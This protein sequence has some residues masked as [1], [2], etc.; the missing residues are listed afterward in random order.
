MGRLCIP[1]L[2]GELGHGRAILPVTVDMKH[3]QYIHGELRET[4]RSEL[5]SRMDIPKCMIAVECISSTYIWNHAER[6]NFAWMLIPCSGSQGYCKQHF[7]CKRCEK[8]SLVKHICLSMYD[9]D[10]FPGNCGVVDNYN[11]SAKCKAEWALYIDWCHKLKISVPKKDRWP[12]YAE[13]DIEYPCCKRA[14]HERFLES[15]L[16]WGDSNFKRIEAVL[17]QRSWNV[18]VEVQLSDAIFRELGPSLSSEQYVQHP[19]R[20]RQFNIGE[21]FYDLY[22]LHYLALQSR[23]MGDMICFLLDR[24][25]KYIG[26]CADVNLSINGMTAIDYAVY[27]NC[28]AEPC[29]RNNVEHLIACGAVATLRTLNMSILK[30][31]DRVF[32]QVLN[33]FPAL[34]HACSEGDLPRY[35]SFKQ[36][37]AI[38][39][40]A[41]LGKVNFVTRLIKYGADVQSEYKG[42]TLDEL[43]LN[44]GHSDAARQIRL[45]LKR[46]PS[47]VTEKQIK[48][49]GFIAVRPLRSSENRAQDIDKIFHEE[50]GEAKKLLREIEEL[51]LKAADCEISGRNASAKAYKEA[52][53]AIKTEMPRVQDEAGD[54]IFSRVNDGRLMIQVDLHGLY[55]NEAVKKTD[56]FLDHARNIAK[57]CPVSVKFIT[58]RGARSTDTAQLRPRVLKH[59]QD[60]RLVIDEE[61]GALTITMRHICF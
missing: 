39:W 54:R 3:E 58:G 32:D 14:L 41:H 4:V 48:H 33:R 35:P 61:V 18:C 19:N 49:E 26:R 43:A 13:S 15:L 38:C 10:R 45:L 27:A 52:I 7:Y 59:L 29:C 20:Q 47:S 6:S 31:G 34:V 57:A 24:I 5:N 50:R 55:V 25:G 21:S 56:C 23:D 28:A 30:D 12:H 51:S 37:S 40:A 11:W 1:L 46:N 8:V 42:L 2:T 44:A 60:L 9:D 22:P 53:N 36:C 16:C 17:D